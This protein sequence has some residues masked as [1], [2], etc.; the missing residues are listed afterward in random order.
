MTAKE[1]LLNS[2]ARGSNNERSSVEPLIQV[3]DAD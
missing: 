2:R 3:F 1:P